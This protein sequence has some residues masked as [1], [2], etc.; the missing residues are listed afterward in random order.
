MKKKW[1]IAVLVLLLILIFYITSTHNTNAQESQE[2]KRIIIPTVPGEV[3]NC[4]SGSPIISLSTHTV[5]RNTFIT[6][7]IDSG[8]V[9]S[10]PYDW[11]IS[12]TG[13]HFN[14]S[15]GPTSEHTKLH[16]ETLQVWADGSACGSARITVQDGCTQ[17]TAS[18]REPNNGN[19][20]TVCTSSGS[21]YCVNSW[22]CGYVADNGEYQVLIVVSPNWRYCNSYPSLPYTLECEGHPSYEITA[23]ECYNTCGDPD[24]YP[25]RHLRSN[26]YQ[27]W[28]C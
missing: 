22:N 3:K 27:Q 4:L 12:G 1:M 18:I 14:S 5:T 6:V 10:P 13:F 20:N 8:S 11:T 19:W 26:T 23:G 16:S 25:C 21:Y 15:S 2:C 17:S 9:G 24:E 28:R 7:K